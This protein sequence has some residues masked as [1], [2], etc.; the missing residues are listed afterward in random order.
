M[1][2]KIVTN[3]LTDLTSMI[4]FAARNAG[5]IFRDKGV[6][7]PMYH[8]IMTDGTNVV[9][10]PPG[11]SKDESVALVRAWLQINDIDRFVYID[12]A[13]ILDTTKGGPEIDLEKV[14]REGIKDHPDRRE[15]VMYAAEN[16]RGEMLTAQQFILRPEIGKAKLSA[17]KIMEQFEHSEGRMVGLLQRDRGK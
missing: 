14:R 10:S 8:A 12:E 16:R 7:Y 13:W 15:I 5:R 9:L 1:D 4:E 6:I 2:W 11:G 3:K 17:L